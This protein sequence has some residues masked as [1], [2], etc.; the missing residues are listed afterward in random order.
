LNGT[1]SQELLSAIEKGIGRNIQMAIANLI[2]NRSP[3]KRLGCKRTNKLHVLPVMKYIVHS[4][5]N[6]PST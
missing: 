6:L 3:S 4:M 2:G 1:H 5:V